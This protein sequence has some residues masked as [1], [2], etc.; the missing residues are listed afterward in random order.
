MCF[1]SIHTIPTLSTGAMSCALTRAAGDPSLSEQKSNENIAVGLSPTQEETEELLENDHNYERDH[2]PG[3]PTLKSPGNEDREVVQ[4][5]SSATNDGPGS[6]AVPDSVSI[7]ANA[8]SN[9][10]MSNAVS[11]PD[12][13]TT[14]STSLSN[15]NDSMSLLQSFVSV[16]RRRGDNSNHHS[17]SNTATNVTNTGNTIISRGSNNSS[18]CSLVRLALSSNF[19]GNFFA[20]LITHLLSSNLS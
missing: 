9:S 13:S 6:K 10:A 15:V 7:R 19:P 2:R 18:V 11:V 4:R 16:A 20:L 1:C 12:L 17:A 5:R 14:R 3:T 8:N